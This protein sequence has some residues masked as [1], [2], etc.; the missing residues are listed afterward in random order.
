MR[1]P[2][3]NKSFQGCYAVELALGATGSNRARVY[4]F[5]SLLL[6]ELAL[7]VGWEVGRTFFFED[8]GTLDQAKTRPLKKPTM[9]AETLP[10]VIGASKKTRPLTAMGSLFKAP[11]ME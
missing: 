4:E 9:M 11:T 8:C 6:C 2:L 1:A 3:L 10:K 5:A 7:I